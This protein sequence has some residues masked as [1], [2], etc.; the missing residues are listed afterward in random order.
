MERKIRSLCVLVVGTLFVLFRTIVAR[1]DEWSLSRSNFPELH[2]T[3]CVCVLS[4]NRLDLLRRTLTSAIGFMERE[5][6]RYEIAWVDNGSDDREELSRLLRDFH[7]E[8]SLHLPVNY[9]MAF[10]FNA[11]FFGLC[12]A[13]YVL[14]LEEDWVARDLDEDED[15]RKQLSPWFAPLEHA[16]SAISR[17]SK[18]IGIILRG[19]HDVWEHT[20]TIEAWR[21]MP[22]LE[23]EDGDDW[24]YRRRCLNL[25]SNNVWGAYSNGASL[26]DRAR[27]AQVGR[28]YGEPNDEDGFPDPYCEANYAL[29]VGLKYCLGEM[30]TREQCRTTT[31]NAIFEHIGGNGRST[32]R[33]VERNVP[34]DPATKMKWVLHGTP[35]KEQLEK[36]RRAGL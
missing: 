15:D 27:L 28:M 36:A 20:P 34:K 35:L 2:P 6:V 17:D 32:S 29:R 8:K 10:G 3:V 24:Q 25:K 22:S 31:C 1:T 4:W 18:L 14:T 16:M 21:T 7:V 11:L 23:E 13:P 19:E 9:G 5:D 12:S 26:Y 30:R 33:K